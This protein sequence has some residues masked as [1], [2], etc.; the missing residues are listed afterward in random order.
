MTYQNAMATLGGESEVKIAHNT[1]LVRRGDGIAIRLYS[2]DIITIHDD[3]TYTLNVGKWK[4]VT[5]KNRLNSYLPFKIHQK[6]YQW[7]IGTLPF[8]NG[9]RLTPEG[10]LCNEVMAR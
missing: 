8:E 2:T 10:V 3:N 4:T 1:Y 7:F 6:D 5:T 9:M